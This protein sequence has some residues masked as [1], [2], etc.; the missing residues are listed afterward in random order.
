LINGTILGHTWYVT[1]SRTH[2]YFTDHPFPFSWFSI[3]NYRGNSISFIS[4]SSHFLFQIVIL[5]WFRSW[6]ILHIQDKMLMC[7]YI[8]WEI[9]R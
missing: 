6:H 7:C 8:K 2:I 9:M 3:I 1:D 5:S 4:S